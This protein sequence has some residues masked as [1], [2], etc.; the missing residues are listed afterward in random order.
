MGRAAREDPTTR[1]GLI[2]FN[3]PIDV[4]FAAAFLWLLIWA[5]R[6]QLRRPGVLQFA[7]LDLPQLAVVFVGLYLAMP[8]RFGDARYLEVRALTYFPVV[9]ARWCASLPAGPTAA[10]A[11]GSRVVLGG[12][13]LL[14]AAN[15][16]DLCGYS[17]SSVPGLRGARVLPIYTGVHALTRFPFLHVGTFVETDRQVIEPYMFAG[18]QGQPM[19]YFGYRN[20][21]YAPHNAG[22]HSHRPKR[23]TGRRSPAHTTSCWS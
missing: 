15:L 21:P 9:A 8:T 6:Y 3:E 17:I 10:S 5:T 12:A 14:L 7:T 22:T 16:N 23:S 11:M 19:K 4:V 13:T 1:R 2:R 20:H 18:D